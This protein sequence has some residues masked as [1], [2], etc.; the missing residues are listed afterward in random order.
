MASINPVSG[1]SSSFPDKDLT[2]IKAS[3][4]YLIIIAPL[5]G[6]FFS[7]IAFFVI[8][9]EY[10]LYNVVEARMLYIE[11]FWGLTRQKGFPD[12]RLDERLKKA[13]GEDFSVQ[14]YIEILQPIGTFI[15]WRKDARIRALFLL[16]FIVFALVAILEIVFYLLY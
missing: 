15:P 8:R 11:N 13:G 16:G 9:K 14:K 10:H 12:S 5:L 7:M 6:F 2:T 1:A 4:H 3:L